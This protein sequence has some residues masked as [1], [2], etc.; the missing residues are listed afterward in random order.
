MGRESSEMILTVLAERYERVG[1]TFI[2]DMGD[3]ERLVA[4]RPDAIFLGMKNL[5][6]TDEH[7]SVTRLWLTAYFEQNGIACTGS[8]AHAIAL[9]FDKPAAKHVVQQSGL[10]T[11]RFFS[12]VPGEFP[13][14]AALPLSFPLFI[15]PPNTGGGKGIDAASVVHDFAAFTRKVQAI[16]DEFHTPA[17]AESYLTGR[18]FSVGIFGT[19]HSS[20]LTAMPIELIADQNADGDRILGQSVKAADT[21]RVIGVADP[22]LRLQLAD[23]AVLVFQALGARDYGRIDIRLDAAGVPQFLEAN[24]IPGVAKHAFTSYFTSSC[25][26][27]LAM[28]HPTMILRIMELA[29]NRTTLE[30]PAPELPSRPANLL[31]I[32]V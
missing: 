2:A 29:L 19:S 24:L 20:R 6:I 7:G 1:I 9:D 4:Q 31:P 18:E 14:A 30:L 16:A 8:P 5:P 13:D 12:A 10:N 23:F 22:D 32:A 11:A 26:I 17:L 27:N 21:E 25:E 28:N 15:K 3:L